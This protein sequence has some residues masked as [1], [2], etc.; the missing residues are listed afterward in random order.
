[1]TLIGFYRL[2]GLSGRWVPVVFYVWSTVAFGIAV[3]QLWSYAG[4]VFNP[5]QARR[6]FAF[7]GAGGLL[8]AIPGGLLARAVSVRAGTYATL[9][10]SGSLFVA[11]AIVVFLIERRRFSFWEH[12]AVGLETRGIQGSSERGCEPFWDRACWK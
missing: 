1:M 3:S 9:L 6:L 10:I 2:F 12:S 8:G 7:V 11:V 4:Q 5:R